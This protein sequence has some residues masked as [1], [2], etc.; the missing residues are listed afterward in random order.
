M[1]KFLQL[2]LSWH[3]KAG[4][5]CEFSKKEFIEGLQSLG[6]VFFCDFEMNFLS[7]MIKSQLKT[8]YNCCRIDSLEK[9]REKIPYMRSELKDERMGNSI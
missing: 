4:T 9:F 1:L 2:V 6:W 3:M 5:M 7:I 8:L